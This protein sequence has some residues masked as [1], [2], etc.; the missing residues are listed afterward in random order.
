M[1]DESQVR[2]LVR[3]MYDELTSELG[4]AQS[5]VESVS[6]HTT[7]SVESS[8]R[9]SLRMA[10]AVVATL[11][12]E[13]SFSMGLY[14]GRYS[15]EAWKLRASEVRSLVSTVL[16]GTNSSPYTAGRFWDEVVRPTSQTVGAAVPTAQQVTDLVPW[17]AAALIAAVLGYIVFIVH[18]A[19]A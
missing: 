11:A 12:P 10:G 13:G 15:W 6:W 16:D 2:P 18:G 3:K 8:W 7:L 17:V 1:L 9:G 19:L 14:S 4:R 5:R